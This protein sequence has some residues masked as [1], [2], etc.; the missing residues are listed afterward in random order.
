MVSELEKKCLANNIKMTEQR[1]IIAE[2]L[3]KSTDH[4]DVQKVY[5]RASKLDS[6]ISIATV[7][8]TLKLFAEYNIVKKHNFIDDSQ[9]RYET[10][11]AHHD[12][13][14]DIESGK[15]IEFYDENLELLKKNIAKRHGY[16]LIE[17]RLELYVA[18]LKKELQDES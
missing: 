8:R 2:V 10:S 15:V 3:S 13:M 16:N 9:S 12:H 5:E 1:R 18:P 6:S 14:I 7:Y 11:T 4:P 17:H